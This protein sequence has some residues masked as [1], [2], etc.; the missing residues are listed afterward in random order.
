[1]SDSLFD[2]LEQHLRDPFTV[3]EFQAWAMAFKL[4]LELEANP[5]QG[6]R[7]HEIVR[8]MGRVLNMDVVDGYVGTAFEDF[9]GVQ[10][11][12]LWT[13]PFPQTEDPKSLMAWNG[14]ILDPWVQAGVPRAQLISGRLEM[15]N[16]YIRYRPGKPRTDIRNEEIDELERFF[17]GKIAE[18]SKA[19]KEK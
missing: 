11:S 1:M 10:H 4:I 15:G 3:K 13:A 18:W 2:G 19:R 17:E 14:N 5:I 6:M 16:L 9:G 8:A 7:C 12:W